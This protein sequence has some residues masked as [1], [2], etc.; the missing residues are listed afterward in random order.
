[1]SEN[2][3]KSNKIKYLKRLDFITNLEIGAIVILVIM[4]FIAVY[5][6]KDGL[7]FNLTS[8]HPETWAILIIAKTVA[9]TFIF[10]AIIKLFALIAMPD[11]AKTIFVNRVALIT[12]IIISIIYIISKF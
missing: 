8:I 10:F 6:I 3:E 7:R 9:T 1:M 4:V 11:K 2:K 5:V 12:S